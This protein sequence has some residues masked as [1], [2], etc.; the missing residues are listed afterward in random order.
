MGVDDLH[1]GHG[2]EQKEQNGGDLAYVLEQVVFGG[3]RVSSAEHINR[4][5][6]DTGD[7]G[8]GRFVNFNRMLKGDGR[9]AEHEKGDH[10]VHG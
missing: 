8:R 9:I 5:K 2:A 7:Q 6:D 4:P 10:H 1:N 3:V